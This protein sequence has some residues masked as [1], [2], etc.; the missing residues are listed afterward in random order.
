M[1]AADIEA[2]ALTAVHP[3]LDRDGLLR[4]LRAASIDPAVVDLVAA[5][6]DVVQA[7]RGRRIGDV[8]AYV[9]SSIVAEPWRWPATPAGQTGGE[10]GWAA[11]LVAER[12][13]RCE[14]LGHKR[15]PDGT[16]LWC[17]D[18]AELGDVGT[19]GAA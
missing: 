15:L 3:G 11:R 4:R 19:E 7:T 13:P 14:R 9:G 18:R 6:T 2:A 5:A 17:E 8:T 1:S 10:E 12:T 16:C